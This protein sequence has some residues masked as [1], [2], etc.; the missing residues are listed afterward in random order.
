MS[1]ENQSNQRRRKPRRRASSSFSFA[2]FYVIFVIGSSF[3]IACIGWSMA[4]DLLALDKESITATITISS[5]DTFDDVVDIL[6]ENGLIEYPFLFK[7][8]ASFTG[9][10]EKMSRGTYTLDT[11]MDYSALL[12]GISATAETRSTVTITI[13]EGYTLDQIFALLDEAGVATVEDLEETAANYDYNF[14]FLQDI[15]LGDVY[16]LEGYLF[17]DTYT[18]Y[19]P[20]DT[21]YAINKMLVAFDSY[22]TDEMREYTEELGYTIHEI[23]TIA[24]MIE[25]ETDGTDQKNI[26]SVIYNRLNNPTY[27]TVG[28]LQIDATIYYA[29]GEEVTQYLRENLDSPYNTHINAG[30]PPG[31]IASPG[32]TSIMAALYPEDTN[33]FYYALGDDGLHHYYTTYASFQEFLASQEYYQNN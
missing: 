26:A 23:L 7:L 21:V 8:F 17:P 4:N 13:P 2:L 31:P 18:F 19:T 25:R 3:L 1:Q 9:G 16:R 33:Y 28:L 12:T 29:T 24:S 22:Y 27:E 5:N 20:N 6:E 30:L 11:D 32:L 14:S 15:P 10:E